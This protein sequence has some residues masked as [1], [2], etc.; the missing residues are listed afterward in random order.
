MTLAPEHRLAGGHPVA[1]AADGVDLAVVRDVAVRVAQRPARERVGGEAG[2]HDH[3]RRR[4]AL[5]T[6]VGE[7]L[8]ELARGEHSLV[9]KGSRRQRREVDVGGVLGALAQAEGHPVEGQLGA[10]VARGHHE[11]LHAREAGPGGPAEDL[12]P[13]RDDPP[14]E[15]VQALL[16]GDGLH[17]AL[18]LELCGVVVGQERH[19]DGVAALGRQLAS[20]VADE[21]SPEELVGDLHDHARAVTGVRFGAGGTAVVQVVQRGDALLDDVV[22]GHPGERR[23]EGDAAGVV[24]ERRGSRARWPA[25]RDRPGWSGPGWSW[26]RSLVVRGRTGRGAGEYQGPMGHGA[27]AWALLSTPP[28]NRLR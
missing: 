6:E 19:A 20:Q 9:H 28:A 2:V 16:V 27:G 21:H 17:H 7:E 4:E 5:V 8:V 26:T 1:V 11:Q 15:D 18:G 14:A 3:Q 10:A 24:L 25:T 23:D 12:G 22:A 13:G